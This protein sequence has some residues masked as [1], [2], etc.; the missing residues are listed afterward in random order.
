MAA[1][2]HVSS[3]N[4]YIDEQLTI[5]I[6]GCKENTK[7]T[8]HA[9]TYDEKQKKF[10]SYATFIA[11]KKGIVDISS[12][13]PI[14][15]SYGEADTAGLF[16]SMRCTSSKLDDYFEKNNANKVSINLILEAEKEVFDDI[17]IH[18]YFYMGDT[19]K[20]YV[21][22]EKIK[23]ALFHPKQKGR[24]PAA[25]I[26]SGSDGG[27]QEHAAALLA[28]KGYVTLALAYFGVEGLPKNLE[29]IPIEYFQEATKWLKKLPYV[30]GNISLIGHSRGGEL[31]LLLG[32][33]FDDYQSIIASAPSA[34]MTPGM[35]NGIFTSTSSWTL[36]QQ[37]LPN[38]TFKFRLQT[39]FSM[40]KNWILKKPISYL[41][42]WDDT[43]KIQEKTENARISVENIRIPIMFIAGRDDQLWP[44]S[45]Y[46]NAIENSL[47][48]KHNRYLYYE[49]AGHFLSFPYS[50][51]NLPA[52]VFMNVV[53]EMVMT[54]GGFKQANAKAAKNSWEEILTFLKE[55][56]N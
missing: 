28:S 53:G 39:I 20:E 41:S 38:I 3:I 5:K 33:I 22:E 6:T 34:Y 23:G 36:N 45:Q 40:L 56:N 17:T 44:S 54:F 25:L 21:Q 47:Q 55:N 4:S 13:Q 19:I 18:R 12:Q 11:N 1:K 27:M 10:R 42:I 32:A 35:R 31:A 52:N 46:V 9:I 7:V 43:L 37:P 51:V 16:W 15:G 29:N 30:N 26:L 49:N 14:A 24:Y 48:N 50:F 2:I 8:V